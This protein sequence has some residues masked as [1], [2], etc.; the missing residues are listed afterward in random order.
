MGAPIR[1]R[2]YSRRGRIAIVDAPESMVFRAFRRRRWRPRGVQVAEVSLLRTG[3]Y[4]TGVSMASRLSSSQ[5]SMNSPR[6]AAMA[7][8]AGI[9][10][11]MCSEN[12]DAPV[13]GAV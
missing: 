7:E 5:K 2:V 4:R 3:A 12:I 11:V 9:P 1:R 13:W 6:T 10:T 8:S